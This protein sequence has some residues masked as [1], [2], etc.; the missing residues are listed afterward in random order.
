M[1]R[2]R[3]HPPP[4]HPR[5][6][7]LLD[8]IGRICCTLVGLGLR[9]GHP[10]ETLA[11]ASGVPIR[12]R[13]ARSSPR[14]TTNLTDLEELLPGRVRKSPCAVGRRRGLPALRH[15]PDAPTTSGIHVA[16][17]AGL[18]AQTVA[19]VRD[20]RWP[21]V[22]HALA[23]AAGVDPPARPCTPVE[24]LSLDARCLRV[25]GRPGCPNSPPHG[26][27]TLFTQRP[28]S[29]PAVDALKERRLE[30]LRPSV[31]RTTPGSGSPAP[32]SPRH[33]PDPRRQPFPVQSTPSS[34]CKALFSDSVQGSG[35]SAAHDR[36]TE[37]GVC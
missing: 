3:S 10:P 2:N 11:G 21:A 16:K 7:S 4:R 32:S 14:T 25:R 35:N 1:I 28:S 29:I 20:A 27:L 8:E 23:P 6:S 24:P 30:A 31:R 19:R 17:L 26:Q 12:P 34:A 37:A 9:L 13:R 5:S 18:P 36:C 22:H 33:A 15:S